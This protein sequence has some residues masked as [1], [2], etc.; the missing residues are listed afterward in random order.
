[1]SVGTIGTFFL[2][3]KQNRFV[4]TLLVSLKFLFGSIMS[5]QKE[6]TPTTSL[7][8]GKIDVSQTI[9]FA[10]LPKSYQDLVVD[11]SSSQD[12]L[13]PTSEEVLRRGLDWNNILGAYG[14]DNLKTE[15]E[16]IRKFD[17]KRIDA[18][19]LASKVRH[20]IHQLYL[21]I[22]NSCLFI[23]KWSSHQSC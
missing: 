12:T 7:R 22:Q 4:S 19:A 1:M 14:G 10:G 17:H 21:Y 2:Q 15:F 3:Q 8:S 9:K 16:I 6:S 20:L 18:V 13:M 11:A 5:N 23:D